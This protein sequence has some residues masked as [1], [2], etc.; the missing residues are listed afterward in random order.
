[1]FNISLNDLFLI[2]LNGSFCNFDDEN[3]IYASASHLDTVLDGLAY[4][5]S[6]IL[7]RSGS[8]IVE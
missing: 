4:D 5:V 6:P 7:Q 8:S 3:A 2:A 1:M